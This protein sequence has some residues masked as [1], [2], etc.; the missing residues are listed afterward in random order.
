MTIRNLASMF[1]PSSVALIGAG[2]RAGSIGQVLLR[3]MRAS[4]FK[5][6]IMPVNPKHTSLEGLA[7]YPDVASLPQAPDLAVLCIPPAVIPQTLLQLAQRGTRAAVVI[8]AGF[9]ESGEAEGKRLQEEMLK[10]AHAHGM[11][12]IGPNCLGIM[13][14]HAGL[15][16]SFSHLAPSA[17]SL[18]F[19]SQSG[20]LC[21]AVLDYI[22]NRDIGFSHFVS[23]GNNADVDFGDMLDYLA[24]DDKTT[25][26]LLYVESVTSVRKFMSAARAAAR[27]KPVI[28]IKSGRN[29][30][31]AKAAASHTGALI[32]S[33][34]VYDVAFKRAGL[35]RVYG[36]EELFDAVETLARLA[37]TPAQL[38][39]TGSHE[40]EQLAI[41][42]NGGGPAVLA[43]DYLVEQ[44]GRLAEL[45]ADTLAKLNAV[46]PK[47]WSH[48]NPVD[49]IGDANGKRY[50]DAIAAVLAAPEID[51]VFVMKCPTA[52]SDN[53]E[54]AKA[55]VSQAQ[56]YAQSNPQNPKRLMTCWL[57]EAT[58]KESRALFA[59][60]QIPTYDTPEKAMR[61]FL[62]IAEYRHNQAM[63][64]E[65]PPA[66]CRSVEA[67]R[68]AANAIINK[69]LSAGRT[70]LFEDEAK[71]LM[72]AY[73]IP[74]VKTVAVSSV[75]E[76]VQAAKRIGYPVALKILSPDISH[77]SDV[78]GVILNLENDDE[79]RSAAESMNKNI[80]NLRPKAQLQGFTVQQMF[81]KRDGYEL[82]VGV[83]TDQ[84]F[85]P[86]VMF[87]EGGVAVEVL[88][89]KALGLPPLNSLLAEDMVKRTRVYKRLKGFR[90]RKPVNMDAVTQVLVQ[91]SQ[92]V[93][94]FPQV[95]ELDINPL[96]ADSQSV[97]ALDARV[98]LS[99]LVQQGGRHLAICPYPEALEE[100]ASLRDGRSVDLRPVRPE[101]AE[102]LKELIRKLPPE[103]LYQRFR[104][105]YPALSV[106][107]IARVTQIDYD[108]DMIF[109]AVPK[110][111]AGH[112]PPAEMFACLLCTI[113]PGSSEAEFTLVVRPDMQGLGIGRALTEKLVRY[114]KT[115][116]HISM[117]AGYA[118]AANAA[119]REMVQDVGFSESEITPDMVKISMKL[120]EKKAA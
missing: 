91:V 53:M 33:D 73:G 94:D 27:N 84:Q 83:S 97:M 30:A 47:T 2:T 42:T 8:S 118:F 105:E 104:G 9:A 18:A 119:L 109:V 48:G 98:K 66:V 10:N 25:A 93:T 106:E 3:N 35:L 24:G 63:L 17:G 68:D 54:V 87:G 75:D 11:R 39:L 111:D 82:I 110:D 64:M 38:S 81:A 76:A 6:A 34:A 70:E 14:P 44:G 56:S 90:D 51:A 67:N 112:C 72:A 114:M 15:N 43:T 115:K 41:V 28:V 57:G 100:R 96:I 92:L 46:L 23:L 55:V 37:G 16:A 116:L 21:T 103:A 1:N 78:G 120:Q 65:V 12:I 32:G 113:H 60:A 49:I 36:T 108:R 74:I 22:A 59:D 58:A 86:V 50:T 62:H 7:C 85:G 4:G 79:V 26:I 99:N 107:Q 117:L 69:A 95:Q 89:D 80:A 61:A 52:V 31:G 102:A 19:V 101:D 40:V 20:A 45:S 5:G 88:D 13:V 71:Q 77:K 29:K